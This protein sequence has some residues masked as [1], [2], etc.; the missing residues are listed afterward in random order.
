[1]TYLYECPK[2]GIVHDPVQSTNGSHQE[3]PC[4][5][6]AT[7]KRV[8]TK[9]SAPDVKLNSGFHSDEL[10]VD[11]KSSGEF[12]QLKE[13]QRYEQGLNRFLGNN[14]TPKDEWV[15]AAAKKQAKVDK[16]ARR[17]NEEMSSDYADHYD[18][19]ETFTKTNRKD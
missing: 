10:G 11:V 12:D 6:G 4:S 3:Y 5:C 14:A 1:M 16:Q 19:V 8:Y 17:D 15:E 18:S 9:A 7:A 2:C 13:K